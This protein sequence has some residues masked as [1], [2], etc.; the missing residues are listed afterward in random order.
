MTENKLNSYRIAQQQIQAAVK[1]LGLSST[2]YELLKQPMRELTVAIPVE[3]DDGSVK[4]F[5]GYRVQH[6]HA[7]GPLKGGIR[8][9]PEVT[10]DE[11]RALAMWMTFKCAVVGLPYGGAKGGVICDPK[12]LSLRELQRL[13][14]GYVNAVAPL[15]GIEKDIPAPDVY[16]NAQVMAWMMDEFSKIKQ[17]NEFGVITGKPQVVGG[18]AGRHEATA[19]GCMI[20]VREAARALEIPL[21][22]AT[23]AVQGFGNAGS[24]IARL[25]HE[26]GC[27]LVAAVDSSGGA[28]NRR[29]LDP[30][31]LA[32]YKSKTG[33]V[34]GYPGSQNITSQ[35]LLTLDCDILIPAA[36]ENQIT[37]QNAPYVKA[38]IIGEAANGPTTPEA[39]RILKENRTLVIPDILASAGGVTV[40]YFEWV[41][42]RMGYYWSTE[43]VNKKLEDIMVRSFREVYQTYQQRKDVDMRTAAYMVAI[44]RISE[45][46]EVRGWLGEEKKEQRERQVLLA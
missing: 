46:M 3:M 30:I 21:Q 42:N 34:K 37:A 20:V 7:L 26:Q 1:Q 40:S 12:K 6:N 10:L 17:Y 35:E 22:G 29:G 44:K 24:I 4:V 43:E 15:L 25:L 23:V 39:D 19:R 5:I 36:L 14:R 11:V 32:E 2:V 38:R 33:S 18:S 13:S 27:R 28:Y 41:Q 31:R 9:H 8:F 16:T 45:A